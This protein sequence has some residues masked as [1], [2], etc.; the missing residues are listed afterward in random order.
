MWNGA[1]YG[2]FEKSWIDMKNPEVTFWSTVEGLE[3][4]VPV[5]KATDYL[6][7]WFKNMPQF[8]GVGEARIEDQGTFKRCP[9][10]VDMFTNAYVVPMWCDLELEITQQGF[11]YK[12][13]NPN[14]IFEGHTNQ[15]FVDHNDSGYK[16]IV[17]AVSPWKAKTPKGYN[18]LQL[19]MFYH[20]NRQW[21]VLPGAI[22][23]DIHH[24]MNQQI[25]VK[26]YGRITIEK[27]TPLCMYMAVK[28]E[29]LDLNISEYTDELKKVDKL[30]ELN[31]RSKFINAYRDMKK[32]LLNE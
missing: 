3:Q 27:G 18:L 24:A 13:S 23:S 28:R 29:K 1:R 25:A 15:Q 9:A 19:P 21:E 32:R 7:Q 16:F 12:A 26:E 2:L 4:V 10:I 17:K 22:Y 11:R 31:I 6:P 20:Y 14:F 30:N 5:K 8:S